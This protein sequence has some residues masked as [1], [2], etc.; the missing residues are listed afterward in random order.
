MAV[1]GMQPELSEKL[2]IHIPGLT[3]LKEIGEGGF[4]MVYLANRTGAVTHKVAIK[5]L[6]AGL[7]TRQILRRFEIEQKA[8]SHLEHPNIAR[9]YDSGETEKGYPYFTMEYIEGFPITEYFSGENLSK[10]LETFLH[11]CSGISHA[12]SK[13]LIHRDLKPSNILVTLEGVP[14]VIDFGIAKATDPE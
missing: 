13:G 9:I 10:M 8:L 3:I 5:I 11:V 12:H 4:G 6:K 7:D 2:G 14:K 1:T